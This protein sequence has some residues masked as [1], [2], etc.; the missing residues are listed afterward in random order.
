MCGRDGHEV[1]CRQ[2]RDTETHCVADNETMVTPPG[3]T[4][5]GGSR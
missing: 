4:A 1:S 3:L 5:A 2:Y